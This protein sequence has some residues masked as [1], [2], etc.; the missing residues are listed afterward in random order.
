MNLFNHTRYLGKIVT[1]LL[2]GLAVGIMNIGPTLVNHMEEV[3]PLAAVSVLAALL[4]RSVFPGIPLL[5]LTLGLCAGYL[6]FLQACRLYHKD[7]Y[8]M[9]EDLMSSRLKYHEEQARRAKEIFF[10]SNQNEPA[11]DD[12]SGDESPRPERVPVRILRQE[13]ESSGDRQ[14]HVPIH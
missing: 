4:L 5:Q 8:A 11:E 12:Y 2:L 10:G 14:N 9:E 6:L 13:P 1:A 7:R 3:P